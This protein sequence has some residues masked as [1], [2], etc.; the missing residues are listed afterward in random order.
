MVS[1]KTEHSLK[2]HC[3]CKSKEQFLEKWPGSLSIAP[4]A[5]FL[6]S[7]MC[8]DIPDKCCLGW[9]FKANIMSAKSHWQYIRLTLYSE[10]AASHH[11]LLTP[12]SLNPSPTLS[13]TSDKFK[14]A[15]IWQHSWPVPLNMVKII[16]INE[17]LR[18][19]QDQRT[20]KMQENC[21]SLSVFGE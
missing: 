8:T 21:L 5:G 18:S 3:W 14:L 13:Q 6:V 2:F 15:T 4:C 11:S 20:L 10:S 16:G 17:T 7:Y 9:I 19:Y 1:M 12:K